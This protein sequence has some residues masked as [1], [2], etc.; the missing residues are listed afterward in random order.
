MLGRLSVSSGLRQQF[1]CDDLH[2]LPR[3]GVE[4]EAVCNINDLFLCDFSHGCD[5]CFAES[6]T[7][8]AGAERGA[9][10]SGRETKECRQSRARPYFYGNSIVEIHQG[11]VQPRPGD[12][13]RMVE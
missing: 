11:K 5:V 8:S 7:R 2:E 10:R 1:T 9:L 13:E 4:Q 12:A 3:R 6:P